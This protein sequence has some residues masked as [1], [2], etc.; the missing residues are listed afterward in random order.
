M[1]ISWNWDALQIATNRF[2]CLKLK[3]YEVPRLKG[4][5][6]NA[7]RKS[8]QIIND[9]YRQTCMSSAHPSDR[10]PDT[11]ASWSLPFSGVSS[12]SR[13]CK[14]RLLYPERLAVACRG[15]IFLKWNCNSFF[16]MF[17]IFDFSD[18]TFASELDPLANILNLKIMGIV[19]RLGNFWKFLVANFRT[20]EAQIFGNFGAIKKLF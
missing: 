6:Q 12:G 3:I 2:L 15:H 10:F 20:K 1:S 5:G 8:H 11:S 19:T 4:S 16:Q 14:F 9:S 13:S 17:Y 18:F 7:Q